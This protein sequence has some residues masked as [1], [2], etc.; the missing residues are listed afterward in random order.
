MKLWSAARWRR[1]SGEPSS[2]SGDALAPAAACNDPGAGEIDDRAHVS[3]EEF[4]ELFA[5]V[6]A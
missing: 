4:A 6:S 1:T 5:A 3:A 2:H